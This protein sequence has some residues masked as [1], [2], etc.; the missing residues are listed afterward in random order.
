MSFKLEWDKIGE[1]FYETGVDRGVVYPQDNKGEYPAGAA[2]NGL[3]AVN[4]S[5]SGGEPSP[6]YAN[7][8]KYL[9]LMS[10]EELGGTIEA[11]AYPD[12]FAECN[13]LAEL[14]P[15]V[16]IGQQ[17]RKAFGFAY[18]TL[19]GNDVEGTSL[20]YKIVL[21][22]GALAKPSEQSNSTVNDSPEAKTMSWE[23]S[24]TPVEYTIGTGENAKTYVSASIEIDSRD[25]AAE[26]L[27]ALEAV[28]YG[29]GDTEARLPL[30]SEVVTLIGTAG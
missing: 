16:R 28:L 7:N 15:G 17:K 25:V 5:P 13:G 2:W 22:Y 8:H 4:L 14:A 19:I 18:R 24:T 20:G 26:K 9:N 30:P 12:E 29:S 23:F 21:V 3:T 11:F 6:L 1:R 10:V 27:A